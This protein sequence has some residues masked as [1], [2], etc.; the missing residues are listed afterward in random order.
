MKGHVLLLHPS[1]PITTLPLTVSGALSRH[2]YRVVE[3]V[4]GSPGCA[5]LTLLSSLFNPH[6]LIHQPSH[7]NRLSLTFLDRHT[8]RTNKEGETLWYLGA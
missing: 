7:E 8:P 2:G 5:T 6:P 3:R 1:A 4:C